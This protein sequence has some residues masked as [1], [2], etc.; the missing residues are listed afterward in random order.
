MLSSGNFNGTTN[1]VS[2]WEST[3]YGDLRRSRRANHRTRGFKV[4]RSTQLMYP[5][6]TVH[7]HTQKHCL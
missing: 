7:T 2:M 5:T 3:E 1:L 6:S 4:V